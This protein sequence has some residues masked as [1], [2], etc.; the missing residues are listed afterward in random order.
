MPQRLLRAIFVR[1]VKA[2]GISPAPHFPQ[3]AT[4][5]AS[6]SFDAPLVADVTPPVTPQITPTQPNIESYSQSPQPI[7]YRHHPYHIPAH[8]THPL[9]HPQTSARASLSPAGG[10]A[11]FDYSAGRMA[12]QLWR[13]C[14]A[15]AASVGN[16]P[17]H[18][19][20]YAA[21]R[22]RDTSPRATS[23]QF[24]A[25]HAAAMSMGSTL[26]VPSLETGCVL[27]PGSSRSST[28]TLPY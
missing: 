11:P 25:P 28:P 20:R 27:T 8:P 26:A 21:R 9:S 19:V 3:Q 17:H 22:W 6:H 1:V 18:T 12:A 15:Q 23:P 16:T 4:D 2:T 10:L 13:H 5:T 14:T 24:P 7:Q